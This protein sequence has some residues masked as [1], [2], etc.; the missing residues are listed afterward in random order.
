[1]RS[2]LSI[3]LQ[4]LRDGVDTKASDNVLQ[5]NPDK[6]HVLTDRFKTISWIEYNEG[7]ENR[8]VLEAS[9]L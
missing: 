1:M 5:Q 8:Y 7:S 6:Y 4:Y 2:N 3:N 9:F